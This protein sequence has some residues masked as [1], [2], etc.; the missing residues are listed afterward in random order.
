MAFTW[1][2]NIN[3]GDYIDSSNLTEL[4]N[5]VQLLKPKIFD[6]NPQAVKD[7]GT[8]PYTVAFSAD[9]NSSHI[10]NDDA[11]DELQSNLDD[12]RDQNYCRA[13]KSALHL[14]AYS[15]K[16]AAHLTTDHASF[17]SGVNSTY[18]GT[19]HSTYHVNRYGTYYGTRH[20]SYY[21]SRYYYNYGTAHGT[22]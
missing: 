12:L 3:D 16:Q 19:R 17:N 22:W 20:N 11:I 21:T 18:H 4:R 14:T 8:T 6:K 10:N 5:N 9:I 2:E 13:Y 7:D 15:E 1:N